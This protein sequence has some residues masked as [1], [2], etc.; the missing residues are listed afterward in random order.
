MAG[1]RRCETANWRL[2]WLA[3][4][5]GLGPAGR[6]GEAACS[7]GGGVTVANLPAAVQG[8]LAFVTDA[9][10]TA[11][12]GLGTTVTGGGANKVLVYSDGTNWI[13]I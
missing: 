12:L 11:I 1:R 10:T 5:R 3:R 13:Y 4:G 2:T 9:A 7:A 8:G 6:A